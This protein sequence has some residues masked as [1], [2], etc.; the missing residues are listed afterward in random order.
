M[1]RLLTHPGDVPDLVLAI[2]GARDIR[3]LAY[4][5]VEKLIYWIDF[6]SKR[7]NRISINRAYDNGTLVKRTKVLSSSEEDNSGA[8]FQPHDIVIDSF[9]RLLF[10]NDEA[11]NVINILSLNASNQDVEDLTKIGHLLPNDPDH[12]PRAMALHSRKGLIFWVNSAQPVRI[13]RA[14]MDG[15]GKMIVVQK[16]LEVPTDLAIDEADDLL[17]WIDI[18]LQRIE[19]ADLDGSNRKV[20]ISG[21]AHIDVSLGLVAVQEHYVYWAVRSSE[22]I[23]RV[24]KISGGEVQTVKSKVVHLSTLISVKA[25]TRLVNP[26]QGIYPLC[27]QN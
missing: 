6:G 8:L 25:E 21:S 16:Q 7:H 20:L 10:W 27:I 9:H 5:S 22:S 19:R 24:H 2:Q 3:S 15:S 11:T 23:K 18:D 1:S 17:F 13:E 26:C 12:K 4:D 14:N